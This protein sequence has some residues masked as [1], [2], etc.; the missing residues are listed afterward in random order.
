MPKQII[1]TTR[2]MIPRGSGTGVIAKTNANKGLAVRKDGTATPA[3]AVDFPIRASLTTA[4]SQTIAGVLLEYD[5]SDAVRIG[6]KGIYMFQCISTASLSDTNLGQQIITTT[7][8]GQVDAA[9]TGGVGEIV[10]Y[11]NT[12]KQVWVEINIP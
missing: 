10:A 9:A 4:A 1:E 6:T 7:T 12:T 8:A 3:S 2:Q 5:N 11:N